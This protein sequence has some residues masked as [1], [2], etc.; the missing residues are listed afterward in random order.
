M[1]LVC[2]NDKE[3]VRKAQLLRF[4]VT[5]D[6]VDFVTQVGR[7]PKTLGQ[8]H[9][10][11]VPPVPSDFAVCGAIAAALLGCFQATPKDFLCASPRGITFT[12]AY[13]DPAKAFHV[14]VS[15]GLAEEYPTLPSLLRSVAQSP[16]SC[17]SFYLS[18]KQLQTHFK[19][20][21]KKQSNTVRSR[22]LQTTCVLAKEGDAAKED[23][24]VRSLYITP[25]EFLLRRA[26]H[27]DG[28]CPGCRVHV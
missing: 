18:D 27:L 15:A 4:K 11:L 13:T 12:Q 19:R 14:A 23:V 24:K 3:A 10:V 17:L 28:Q 9:V 6:P 21:T 20:K 8:G 1:L 2:R 26:G 5:S 7:I 25:Q 22:V 16:G